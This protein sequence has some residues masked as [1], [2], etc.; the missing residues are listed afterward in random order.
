MSIT[1]EDLEQIEEWLRSRGIKPAAKGGGAVFTGVKAGSY[2]LGGGSIT[3]N[4][5]GQIVAVSP[6]GGGGGSISI[7]D[8]GIVVVPVADSVDFVGEGVSVAAVGPNEAE[9]RIR[10]VLPWSPAVAE[11]STTATPWQ[12]LRYN[13]SAPL[14]AFTISAPPTPSDNEMFQIKEIAGGN[15][16]QVTVSGNGSLIERLNGDPV[17]SFSPIGRS[18]SLTYQFELAQATWRLV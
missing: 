10:P 6:G 1:Q 4:G 18:L 3:V 13:G 9:V 7:L 15:G 14:G 8:E 17:A 11:S 12:T 2:S 16:S 5:R